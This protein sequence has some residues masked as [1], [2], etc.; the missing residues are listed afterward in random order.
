MDNQL[1]LNISN[2]QLDQE[3]HTY[4]YSWEIF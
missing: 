2:T 3:R 4:H 1:Q